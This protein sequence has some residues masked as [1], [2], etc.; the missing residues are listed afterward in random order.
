MGTRVSPDLSPGEVF[1]FGM[2]PPG[3]FG[4]EAKPRKWSDR[5]IALISATVLDQ[6][7][8]VTLLSRFVE[9]DDGGERSLFSDDGAPLASFGAKI[10]MGHALGVYG[11]AARQDLT[12]VRQIRNTFAH[13][14]L[15]I[16][17]D[18][19]EIGEAC[20]QLTLFDRTG[21]GPTPEF[22]AREWFIGTVS[23]FAILLIT[24]AETPNPGSYHSKVLDLA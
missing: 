21:R 3:A 20:R 7:L 14:R 22:D 4:G 12:I 11:V 5:A 19:P 1:P 18:T 13:S 8:E 15:T 9:M 24:G 23:A 10:R 2:L 17:F 16:S 6:G